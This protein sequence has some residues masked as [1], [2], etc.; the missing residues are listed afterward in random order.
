[1]LTASSADGPDFKTRSPMQH[2]SLNAIS[3][4]HTHISP[5]ISQESTTTPKPLTADRLH[6]L[7]QM[8][9]TDPSCKCISKCQLNGKAPHHEFDTCTHMKGLLYKHVTDSGK[10]FLALVIPKSWKYTVL[11]EV[12]DK[13]G[14]QGNSHTYC[15]IKKQYYWKG[16][17]KDIRKYIANCI[18]C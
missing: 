14:H 17:N 15:L 9:R 13:L 8:Q 4:P 18:L 1:M 3:I 16:M 12:H 10:Q 2:T 11:V 6:A 7:L 5:K